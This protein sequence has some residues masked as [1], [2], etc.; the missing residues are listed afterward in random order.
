MLWDFALCFVFS[1]SFLIIG[2]FLSVYKIL[3]SLPALKVCSLTFL[4]PQDVLYFSLF[5]QGKWS[6]YLERW[7]WLWCGEGSPGGQTFERKA[8]SGV[9]N[10]SDCGHAQLWEASR[11]KNWPDFEIEWKWDLRERGRNPWWLPWV[12]RVNT[13]RGASF[14]GKKMSSLLEGL[15]WTAYPVE[16]PNKHLEVWEVWSVSQEN[17]CSLEIAG[18]QRHVGPSWVRVLDKVP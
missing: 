3:K 8:L 15:R 2:S 4:F 6:E 7:L 1:Y 18:S 10:S 13:D 14:K 12:E 11:R 16:K 5:K 9:L 17:I